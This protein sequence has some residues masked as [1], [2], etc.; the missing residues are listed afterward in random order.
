MSC[1]F[2]LRLYIVS[3]VLVEHLTAFTTLGMAINSFLRLLWGFASLISCV[4]VSASVGTDKIFT[5]WNKGN[6][7]TAILL[8][9][10]CHKPLLADL[11]R[12]SELLSS[13]HNKMYCVCALNF[14]KKRPNWFQKEELLKKAESL[15]PSWSDSEVMAWCRLHSPRVPYAHKRYALAMAKKH[16][17]SPAVITLLRRGWVFGEF[18]PAQEREYLRKYGAYI[19]YL[20]H[21][22][23]LSALLM[24]GDKDAAKVQSKFLS[25]VDKKILADSISMI[26]QQG[27]SRE[28]I[29]ASA[30]RRKQIN[31]EMV[32]LF[33]KHAP[34]AQP[35]SKKGLELACRALEFLGPE[36]LYLEK[37]TSA[38][39]K[40]ARDLLANKSYRC[41]YAVISAARDKIA[42][43][44]T[45]F[46]AGWIALNHLKKPGVALEHL[47]KMRPHCTIART[48][49]KNLYWLA[50][51]SFALKQAQQGRVYMASAARYSNTF[52]GQLAMETLKRKQFPSFANLPVQAAPE[53]SVISE[54]ETIALLKAN[55]RSELANMLCSSLF[56]RLSKPE[57]VFAVKRLKTDE[58]NNVP[59][60]A[61][62]GSLAAR[63]GVV[64][65]D[66]LLPSLPIDQE[67][68]VD[69]PLVY[70]II[71]S[72]SCF[73]A[74]IYS[75]AGAAGLMQ[76]MLPTA[77]QTAEKY[78]IPFGSSKDRLDPEVNIQ[79][80]SLY[81]AE[82]LKRYSG[83]YVLALAAY[84]AG[85]SNVESWIKVYGRPKHA[86]L[87]SLV[88]WIESIPFRETREYVQSVLADRSLYNVMLNGDRR[89]SL[90]KSLVYGCR[91]S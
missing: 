18:T 48:T 20:D 30:F 68:E 46:T 73:D 91:K 2:E 88:N 47:L 82:L 23:R 15:M 70:A 77:M 25:A 78:G 71:K 24:S 4:C 56:P 79:L 54:M 59:W 84:N 14:L 1:A 5:H 38:R 75:P 83:S 41:A 26:E 29:F 63:Y 12:S 89:L 49:A 51:A 34:S 53:P 50:K 10:K 85:P 9:R 65:S 87:A 31:H 43:C 58:L 80:G 76:L 72:E 42:L 13:G 7:E 22:N 57:I 6:Y 66:C 55:G 36:K 3:S 11:I 44:K 28:R 62:L 27:S 45:Q 17:N 8:S 52:Y 16:G 64:I 40:L 39:M 21:K 86:N 90:S 74:K 33:L 32:Y 60:N 19:R 61:Y 35:I 67:L 81:I 37:W 69:L